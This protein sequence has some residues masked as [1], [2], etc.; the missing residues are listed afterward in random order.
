MTNFYIKNQKLSAQEKLEQRQDLLKQ[1]AGDLADLFS[2]NTLDVGAVDQKNCENLVGSVEVPVGVAGPMQMKLAIEGSEAVEEEALIPLAATEGAL[3]ASVSRGCKLLSQAG[4]KV[5]VDRAGMTRAP[6]FGFIS[7]A[8]ARNFVSWLKKEQ[9]FQEVKQACETTSAH[10]KLDRY[11][12]WIVGR[13]VYVRFSF[14]T[15][16]AMGMNMVTI[17]L[18]K[19]WE[20]VIQDY[21]KIEL[22]AISGNM[23]ADKK[24]AAVNRLLGRGHQAQAESFISEKLL[25]KVLKVSAEQIYKTHYWKNEVGSR[26]AGA[27]TANMHAANMAAAVFLATGQDMAHV[28]ESSQADLI[29]EVDGGGLYAA[30]RLP[31]INVGVV[32]GGTYLPAF[33]QARHLIFNREISSGELAGVIAAA[34][35]AGELSGLAALSTSSLAKAH[36]E[37][38]R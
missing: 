12:S 36:Q 2:I 4:L 10:L 38:G 35:L 34:V 27:E 19:A 17:A 24:Q 37:L 18:K 29:L 22:L 1:R 21:P 28:V 25:N 15:D 31:N 6:V 26:L 13:S 23:C 9:T 7:Q 8:A 5:Y 11:Q 20:D 3:T 30:V 14:D 33:K 16:Q 32:G